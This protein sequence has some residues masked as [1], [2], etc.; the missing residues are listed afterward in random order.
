MEF[1]AMFVHRPGHFAHETRAA[2]RRA[3]IPIRDEA[4]DE[5]LY[6]FGGD[7]RDLPLVLT[8]GRRL[9]EASP[10]LARAVAPRGRP[11]FTVF[12]Q[13][14]LVRAI[15][16]ISS[17]FCSIEGLLRLRL[18]T[19]GRLD[20]AGEAL[21]IGDEL[22]IAISLGILDVFPDLGELAVESG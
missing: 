3:A 19:A 5:V 20:F 17:T 6:G 12:F 9:R 15:G 14:V 21:Q 10:H 11:G 18:L 13:I 8:H 1:L 2:I 7:R 16:L 4:G 22:G